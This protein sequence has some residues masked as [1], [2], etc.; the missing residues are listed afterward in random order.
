MANDINIKLK[1]DGEKEMKSSL[2][3]VNSELKLM[4][5]ELK[6]VETQSKGAANSEENLR[7]KVEALGK[8]SE[9]A[10]K[11]QQQLAQYV[12]EAKKKQEAAKKAVDDLKASGT[13]NAEEVEKAEKAYQQL[14]NRVNYWETEL[15][16][17]TTEQAKA[18]Q[19]LDA[20][21]GY[22][23]E[24]E[25]A[26]DHLAKSIDEY[27]KE[28][29]DSTKETE[30]LN[31]QVAGLT[32][33]EAV[34]KIADKL[35]GA[36]KQMN[37]A[38]GDAAKEIDAGYDTIVKKTG[39]TGRQ[40]NEFKGIANKIFGSM[41][42]DM[43]SVGKAVGEV[44]TRFR[45]TGSQ[46]QATSE[47]FLKFARVNDVDVSTAVDDV[48]NAL[49]AFNVDVKDASKFLDVLTTTGQK[50]G[51]DVGNLAKKVTENATAFQ[52]MG[53]DIYQATDF[54]G[55]LETAGA[56]SA[57]VLSGLKRA[58]KSATQE[59]IPLN[60]ALAELE[61]TILNG[62]DSA[63]GLTVAYELFGKSGAGIFQAVKNGQISFT[64]LA[65]STTV[66][67]DATDSLNSIYDATLSSWDQA[68]IAQNNLKIVTGNL[69]EQ[70]QSAMT[71]ALEGL[72]AVLQDANEK[73]SELPEGVQTTIAV[74]AG[75]GGKALEVAPQVASLVTQIAALKVAKSV[76]GSTT[77]LAGSLKKVGTAGG[78]AALAIAGAVIAYQKMREE[79]DKLAKA[80][81]DLAN[82]A[83]SQNAGYKE[84]HTE[85]QTLI[86]GT[87]QYVSA[88][89]KRAQLE[90][91]LA[92][93]RAEQIAA[94]QSYNDAKSQLGD[95]SGYLA[96]NLQKEQEAYGLVNPGAYVAS[97]MGADDATKALNDTMTASQ[98]TMQLTQ[99]DIEAIEAELAAMDE[100]ERQAAEAVTNAEGEIVKAKD[101]S[102]T[103]SGEELIAFE[104][105]STYSQNMALTVAES[106]SAM[107]ESITSGIQSQ[108]NWFD[109]VQEKEAQSADVM[110]ANLA[111]QIDALKAWETNLGILA[112]SGIDQNLL[113]YLANMGPEGAAYVQAFVDAANGNTEVGLEE[114]NALWQEKLD[115][116]AG[117]NKEAEKVYEGIGAMA[118]G[119]KDAFNILAEQLNV[120]SED[121]GG[122]IALGL[123]NGIK[124]AQAQ[125]E[126]AAE[127][128]GEDTVDSV[129]EGAQTASPS[130]ATLATGKNVALGLQNGITGGTSAATQAAQ[131]LGNQVVNG[132]K[133]RATQASAQGIGQAFTQAL[134]TS[135]NSA[136]GTALAAGR[137]LGDKVGTGVSESGA[138]NSMAAQAMI[139]AMLAVMQSALTAA[140]AAI[141]AQAQTAGQA[142][143]QALQLG[144]NNESANL[145]NAGNNA[146]LALLAGISAGESAN[147]GIAS[148]AGSD[149]AW[150]AV[151]GALGVDASG[152]GVAIG[153]NL[154]WGIANGIWNNQSIAI[155]A[156]AQ[157]AASV[158]AQAKA[159]LKISSPSKAFEEIGKYSA[160]GMELGFNENLPDLAVDEVTQN[161]SMRL[162]DLAYYAGASSTVNEVRVY[163]G[164]RELASVL[165]GSVIQNLTSNNRAYLASNGRRY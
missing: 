4:Q 153:T 140:Q 7:A 110:A 122:N 18:N 12:E 84:T 36:F 120:S 58:L 114:M 126:E 13:A 141:S 1:L 56:D 98:E 62:T 48:Q 118:A 80:Q 115:L 138:S 131:N 111:A 143:G 87:N 81:K 6:L 105:L 99:A 107:Q 61:E 103:K 10:A 86:A 76:S 149:A 129:A 145:T 34:S 31:K 82:A 51:A 77:N 8:V 45:Q 73:F 66:L 59:G 71:P 132:V 65:D 128:L 27:G 63:D 23:E 47:Q 15:N 124:A 30:G 17:A 152:N 151:N 85:I 38:A 161:V 137:V 11:K 108:I 83:E 121:C 26:D 21:K 41:P 160:E 133:E 60:E 33:M 92:Q 28:V 69:S 24:A 57:S 39:A 46:L 106:I 144:I 104:N 116:E 52:E 102:I 35:S 88:E 134:I 55:G 97:M 158:L 9:T 136:Q 101:A 72:T 42:A 94:E 29:K 25:K 130:K 49:A 112:E 79:A 43:E 19:E 32:K 54:M 127:D 96:E 2:K 90:A 100:A 135:V 148:S 95:T 22:L 75:V 154:V 78:I 67:A 155:A 125:A 37:K 123:A 119:S 74:I 70:F 50:T 164:D 146:A 64:D 165:T 157:M 20:A 150:N 163:V 3:D 44:N 14:S 91:S 162:P 117:V 89:E 147:A 40:L 159:T 156:A 68:Q 113:Q 109:V 139:N 93:V 5:S 142:A 53:L 16:K